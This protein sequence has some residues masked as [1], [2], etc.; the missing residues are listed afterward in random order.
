MQS[1]NI[2]EHPIFKDWGGL[3]VARETVSAAHH[4]DQQGCYSPANDLLKNINPSL[5][6][7]PWG[8]TVCRQ[9]QPTTEGL[10]YLKL[11]TIWSITTRLERRQ[12]KNMYHTLYRLIRTIKTIGW[13]SQTLFIIMVLRLSPNLMGLIILSVTKYSIT[14]RIC[15]R[16]ATDCNHFVKSIGLRS[17]LLILVNFPHLIYC[18]FTRNYLKHLQEWCPHGSNAVSA[19]LA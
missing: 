8:D 7:Y 11:F 10:V 3:K 6:K 12:M 17:C 15:V 1:F 18:L 4:S 16:K 19:G 2:H 13:F 5:C 9:L 14:E